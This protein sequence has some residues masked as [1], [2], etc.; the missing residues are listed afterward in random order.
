MVLFIQKNKKAAD[1]PYLY[2]LVMRSIY[3]RHTMRADELRLMEESIV[4]WAQKI[5]L[6]KTMQRADDR[7]IILLEIL[8]K[9]L[10]Q[11]LDGAFDDR[12]K[13]YKQHKIDWRKAERVP[14]ANTPEDILKAQQMYQEYKKQN[15]EQEDAGLP[16]DP[17][18][19]KKKQLPAA[20]RHDEN[21][22]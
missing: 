9:L 16:G 10:K 17:S 21:L 7:E 5:E 6:D 2:M 3:E 1:L 13:L 8:G 14:G 19:K 20:E 11:D 4:N 18:F 12:K 15:P 22:N